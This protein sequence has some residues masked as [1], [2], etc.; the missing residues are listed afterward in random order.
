[1]EHT[2]IPWNDTYRFK[3]SFKLLVIESTGTGPDLAQIYIDGDQAQAET[4]AAFIVQAVNSHAELV[5]ALGVLL[6]MVDYTD[7]ACF[8]NELVSA[9]LPKEVIEK[10]KTALNNATKS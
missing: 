5:A 9:V 4:D 1:M 10:A 2:P 8:L 6:S 3:R 7:G